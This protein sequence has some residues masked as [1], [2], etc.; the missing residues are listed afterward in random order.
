MYRNR[1]E[2]SE[3]IGSYAFNS[4][5][6]LLFSYCSF[7]CFCI[8]FFQLIRKTKAGEGWEG[9]GGMGGRGRSEGVNREGRYWFILEGALQTMFFKRFL[10]L[11]QTTERGGMGWD[12][13]V[14]R[15]LGK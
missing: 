2:V 5:T 1:V 10:T 7:G 9:R 4:F 6:I 13:V 3:E 12:G 14:R 11:I 15:G 8:L